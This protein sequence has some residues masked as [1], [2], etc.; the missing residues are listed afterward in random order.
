MASNRAWRET[1][2]EIIAHTTNEMDADTLIAEAAVELGTS[3]QWLS[4]DMASEVFADAL[5]IINARA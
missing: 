1:M 3:A 2:Q 4:R 5:N